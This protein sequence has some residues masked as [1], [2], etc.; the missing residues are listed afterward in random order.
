MWQ[1]RDQGATWQKTRELTQGSEMNHT[2]V[3]RVLGGHPDFVALWADGHG[4]K[5]SHSHLYF[6]NAA[7]R[8]FQ[9]PRSMAGDT[10]TPLRISD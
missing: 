2:Y 8:V 10:A 6:S 3:R 4:R 9:L 1:S 5:P 7:G